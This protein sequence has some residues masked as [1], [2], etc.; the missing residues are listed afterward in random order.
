MESTT[1][2][3]LRIGGETIVDGDFKPLVTG[4]ADVEQ[5]KGR[6]LIESF[7]FGMKTKQVLRSPT[8]AEAAANI[9]F[10]RVRISKPFDLASLNLARLLRERTKFH[11]ARITVDQQLEEKAG[12]DLEKRQNAVIVFHL[13]EGYVVDIKLRT[14]TESSGGGGAGVNEDVELSFQ[15]VAVEYYYKGLDRRTGQRKDY[16]EDCVPFQTDIRAQE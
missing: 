8:E 4:E 1:Q 15:N 10:D 13:Q 9:N 5:Y 3:F 12:R 2:I 7:S 11:E 14:A 16:R 6:I